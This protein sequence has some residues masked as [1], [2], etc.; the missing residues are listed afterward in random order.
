MSVC[1]LA[2]YLK[3]SQKVI[4]ECSLTTDSLFKSA[5]LKMAA[6]A[7]KNTKTTIT[8]SLIQILSLTLR[9]ATFIK[10]SVP[11]NL[12]RRLKI[13]CSHGDREEAELGAAESADS[14]SALTARYFKLR[15]KKT[16]C[17][18]KNRHWGLQHNKFHS[19]ITMSD[20]WP[21]AVNDEE[22]TSTATTHIKNSIPWRNSYHPPPVTTESCT[23]ARFTLQVLMLRSTFIYFLNI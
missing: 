5:S 6:A 13:S 12:L 2:K 23:K 11:G 10:S 15:L 18:H 17:S 4:I 19:L 9:N 21:M 1:L 22:F 20:V 14:E 16:K 3:N 8:K 7:Y